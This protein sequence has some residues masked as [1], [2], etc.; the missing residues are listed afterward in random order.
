MQQKHVIVQIDKVHVKSEIAYKG[1]NI[2]ANT[3][4]TKDPIKT[5]LAIMVSSLHKKWST[6]V[7]L[8]PLSSTNASELY[9]ALK[10]VIFDIE[11]CGLFVQVICSDNYSQNVSILKKFSSD[12]PLSLIQLKNPEPYSC[13]SIQFIF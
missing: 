6:I 1:G 11:K 5:V 7:H 4:N 3:L 10:S 8:F 13:Y 9:L 12:H 2:I